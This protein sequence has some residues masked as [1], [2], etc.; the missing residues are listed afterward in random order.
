MLSVQTGDQART[1]ADIDGLPDVFGFKP[2]TNIE[3][4]IE[5]FVE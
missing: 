3:S 4:G 5:G 1:F 2:A